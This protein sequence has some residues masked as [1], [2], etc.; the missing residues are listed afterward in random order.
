MVEGELKKEGKTMEVINIDD[1]ETIRVGM[2]SAI[3]ASTLQ[4]TDNVNYR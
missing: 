4:D 2:N 1:N 3:S